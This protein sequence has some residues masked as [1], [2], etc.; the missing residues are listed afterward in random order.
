MKTYISITIIL[1]SALSSPGQSSFE[2]AN[3]CGNPYYSETKSLLDADADGNVL[4]AGNFID[5]AY[6]GDEHVISLGET[7]IFLAKYDPQGEL[8]WLIGDG[9]IDYDYMQG[10]S[11]YQDGAYA[12]LSFYG[13]TRLGGETYSSSGSQDIVIAH[14]DTEGNY[15]WS[16]HIGSPKTD[17]ANAVD[18]DADG[19]LIVTGHFY[20]SIAFPDT[21][22]YS[23]ASSDIFLASFNPAGDLLWIKTMGGSSTDQSYSLSC[24]DDVN[25]ILTG[26]FFDDIQIGDTMLTTTAPTGV[27]VANYSYA[28]DFQFA[29]QIDGNGLLAQSFASFDGNGNILHAGNFTDQVNLGQYQFNAGPFNIDIFI[30]KYDAEGNLLWADHGHSAGSDQL[31][32][33]DVGPDNKL[34]LTGHYLDSIQFGNVGLAYSL[35]CGSAEIFIV[36][37]SEDG[38]AIW[39]RQISGVTALVEDMCKNIDDKLFLTGMFNGELTLGNLKI[40]SNGYFSNYLTGMNTDLPSSVESHPD[41]AGIR[42]SPNPAVSYLMID[43][44]QQNTLYSYKIFD[45]AGKTS[46]EGKLSG[47]TRVN[48]SALSEGI[49]FLQLTSD[50]TYRKLEKFIV[51][52]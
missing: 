17:Y 9:G 50:K 22:V 37:Y 46:L 7:D 33:I 48:V 20:D 2:W 34:Y 26:S 52:R 24:D 8:I 45:A 19:N 1:L 4:M 18:T 29:W 27:F 15:R 35:C 3:V 41:E 12:L 25:I 5:T 39:G 42:L 13:T 51:K 21:T 47:S 40:Y 30:T 10:I 6:F 23:I 14:Y 38:T 16:R 11:V 44:P 43:P 28:G 32:S 36:K 31:I 49:H